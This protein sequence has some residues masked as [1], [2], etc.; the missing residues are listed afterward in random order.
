MTTEIIK[1]KET[2]KDLKRAQE[3]WSLEDMTKDEID[4]LSKLCMKYK[5]IDSF[6]IITL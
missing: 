3:L 6:E 1:D 2:I 5:N 4:E